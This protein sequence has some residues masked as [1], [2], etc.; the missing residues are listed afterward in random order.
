M[1]HQIE[2]LINFLRRLKKLQ[3]ATYQNLSKN[4]RS[5]SVTSKY[6]RFC[7]SCNL[8]QI[9][10]TRI[11]QGNKRSKRYVLTKNGE[12]FLNIFEGVKVG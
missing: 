10:D 4:R 6:L 8:I 5:F 9:N 2:N 3:P 12:E 7:L 11:V 1:P